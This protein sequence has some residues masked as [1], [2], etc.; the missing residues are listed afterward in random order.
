MIIAPGPF[1]GDSY[2]KTSKIRENPI[3][4]SRSKNFYEKDQLMTKTGQ[5][6]GKKRECVMDDRLIAHNKRLK[7]EAF[8]VIENLNLMSLWK[9]VGGDPYLVGAFA[10]DLALS[11]DI[12]IEI[13]C[14][15]PRIDNGF[16]ILNACARQPG[17]RA[18]RFRNEM[19]GPDQG[20]YWQVQY[21][22]PEGQLWKVD[23]WSIRVDHPG[24][25]SRDMIAP[26]RH[27][28]D[29]EKRSIIL[30]LKQAVTNDPNVTCPSIFL[31][32][33]V[34]ADSIRNYDGL[35]DWLSNHNVEGINDWRQWLPNKKLSQG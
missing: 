34:L 21:Q 15:T 22:Q 16:R 14:E 4:Y 35:L 20:Y 6:N 19:D 10:Y 17:C 7:N 31:Y 23:M 9:E 26:I 5:N 24:P 28:L 13:Y 18:A 33:A 3:G 1:R 27:A 32:Q 2:R 29:R 8:Y 11:P 30:E 12:D 25:T